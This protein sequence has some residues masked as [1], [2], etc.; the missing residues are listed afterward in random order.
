M[1]I[2][3]FTPKRI[4]NEIKKIDESKIGLLMSYRGLFQCVC[5]H[6]V[7]AF[8]NISEGCYC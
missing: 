3:A 5:L 2:R 4:K 6:N 1:M 7:R 8:M